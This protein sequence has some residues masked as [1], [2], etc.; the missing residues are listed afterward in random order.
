MKKLILFLTVLCLS[1]SFTSCLVEETGDPSSG[2]TST[3]GINETATFKT[4]KFT[5]TEIKSS[6]G[7]GFSKPSD[8]NIFVGVNFTIENISNENQNISSMLLFEAYADN[9][10]AS[11][12]LFSDFGST[13][14]GTITPENSLTGFYAVEIP[15]DS[16][17]LELHVKSDWLGSGMAVFEFDI[18]EV[19]EDP[20]YSFGDTFTFDNLEI[21]F[22]DNV[23]FVK[24]ENQFSEYN[25]KDVVKIPVTLKN[26]G[27]ESNGFNQFNC[28]FFGSTGTETD[29]VNHYFED[30][31]SEDLRPDAS[32]DAFL[33]LIY[34]GDGDYVFEF[35]NYSSTAKVSLPIEK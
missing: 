26:I 5:A 11:M 34:D 4:L 17:K 27:K 8:G 32:K 10:K 25:G 15:T 14:D 24:L 6:K 18:P 21:T 28:K 9:A 3:F 2:G 12:S 30:K 7:S 33:Y 20:V 31:L 35:D 23:E 13:L 22:K 16:K 29:Y 1:F 19:P